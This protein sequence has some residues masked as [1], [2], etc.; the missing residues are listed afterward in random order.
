MVVEGYVR[1]APYVM[2]RMQNGLAELDLR[3]EAEAR[4][5]DLKLNAPAATPAPASRAWRPIGGRV[6]E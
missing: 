4:R 2:S 1:T 3:Q 5:G 6:A